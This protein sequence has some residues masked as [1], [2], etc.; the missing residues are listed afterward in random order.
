ML[1]FQLVNLRHVFI[2]L[3]FEVLLP[4]HIEL[5]QRFLTNFNVIFELPLLDIAAKFVLI[6]DNFLLEEPHFSH[7]I[8]IKLIF[9]NLAALVC[10][11]LHLF[12]DNGEKENLF[13]FVEEAVAALIEYFDE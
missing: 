9:E 12:L 7:K 3:S 4:L 11:K 8:F 10:K 5:L 1:L 2:L 13:I 6:S